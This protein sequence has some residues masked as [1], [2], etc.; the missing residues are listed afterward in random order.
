MPQQFSGNPL[1]F[2]PL[3]LKRNFNPKWSGHR[4]GVFALELTP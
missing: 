1:N 3:Q 2:Q 4:S